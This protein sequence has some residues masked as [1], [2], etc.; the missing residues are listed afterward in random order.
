MREIVVGDTLLEAAKTTG[1]GVECGGAAAFDGLCEVEGIDDCAEALGVC[2]DGGEWDAFE[3]GDGA[4]GET[5]GVAGE[6]EGV[7]VG[8]V[9]SCESIAADGTV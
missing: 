2:G 1:V 7:D 8:W 3:E 6:D 5:A 9:V 4:E